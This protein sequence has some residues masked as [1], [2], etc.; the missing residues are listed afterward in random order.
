[1]SELV[2]TTTGLYPHP[3]AARADLAD[4]KGHQ[5][6]DLNDGDERPEVAAVYDRARERILA[7]QREA[8]LGR[9]VE[10]QLRWDDLLAHP[11][12]V[13]DAVETGGIVRYYDNNNF[14][15]EPRVVD[16][17]AP[18]GDPAADLAAAAESVGSGRLQATLPGPYTLADL[19][20]DEHYGDTTELRAAVADLLV[21]E[22]AELPA[23]ET[24]LLAE[25]SLVTNPPGDGPDARASEAIDAV[26]GATDADV[27]VHTYWGAIEEK[28]YAHLL[29]AG[30]D[31]VGVD[32]VAADRDR[33]VYN[34]G[35]YGTTDDLALGVV[36]GQSTRVETA[37][38]IRERVAWLRDRL[39]TGF[40]T[41]Y[42]L[43]NTGSFY[44]PLNRHRE[45]LAALGAAASPD[46]EPEPES[47]AGAG[48]D[49]PG[50]EA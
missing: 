3:D 8:G 17:L 20:T 27:I 7:D 19:A 31:A 45:K 42:L 10:G 44:L 33:T 25:P 41:T 38:T 11:L 2:A 46:A 21:A 16:E 43:P 9:L 12:T 47:G 32:L 23:H 13:T 5:K 49:D 50:V 48:V 14:Y 1:M 35:E 37:E 26:A 34:L 30:I 22:V 29:D 28:V 6:E 39:P 15:R 24:L 18:T 40:D 36:D 4:L